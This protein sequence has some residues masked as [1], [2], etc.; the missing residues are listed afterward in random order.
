M[1]KTGDAPLLWDAVFNYGSLAAFTALG[2]TFY[3]FLA[4]F[5]WHDLVLLFNNINKY[6]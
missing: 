6:P 5:C 4:L 2:L 1:E 3:N